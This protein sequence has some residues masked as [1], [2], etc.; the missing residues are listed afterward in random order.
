MKF[1]NTDSV[2]ELPFLLVTHNVSQ[3]PRGIG[4]TRK[5]PLLYISTSMCYVEPKQAYI[6]RL[7]MFVQLLL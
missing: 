2:S 6:S 3:L 5:D 4:N 7:T 1:A